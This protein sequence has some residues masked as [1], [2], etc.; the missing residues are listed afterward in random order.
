[1][2]TFLSSGTSHMGNEQLI[3]FGSGSVPARV[4]CA[5]VGHPAGAD[6]AATPGLRKPVGTRA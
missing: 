4:H 3:D 6:R 2:Q 5:S 1:M